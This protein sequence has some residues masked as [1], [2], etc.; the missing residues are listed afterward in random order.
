MGFDHHSLL[1]FAGIGSLVIV[2]ENPLRLF[3][4]R[5]NFRQMKCYQSFYLIMTCRLNSID[6]TITALNS[7]FLKVFIFLPRIFGIRFGPTGFHSIIFLVLI[8]QHIDH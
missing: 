4:A 7:I 8:S 6:H 3:T 5:L 1:L 2:A